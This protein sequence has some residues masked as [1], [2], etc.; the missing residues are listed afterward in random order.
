MT[1]NKV[2][3]VLEIYKAKL[4]GS[5]KPIRLKDQKCITNCVWFEEVLDHVMW[6]CDEIPKFD[7]IEKTMRWLGYIQGILHITGH[8]TL[9]EL[10]EQCRSK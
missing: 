5:H 4:N 3:E 9:D 2:L 1:K 7:D 8:Y 10:R 6:M